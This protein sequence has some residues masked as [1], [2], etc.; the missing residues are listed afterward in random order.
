VARGRI[1]AAKASFRAALDRSDAPGEIAE[2]FA[3]WLVSR[4]DKNDAFEVSER[5][6]A[7]GS[8]PDALLIAS[9][10]ERAA[11]RPD[12]AR[13]MAEKALKLGAPAGRA[14]ILSAQALA[15]QGQRAAA[16][17]TYLG[18]PLDAPEAAEA[19]LRA[20][21]LLRDD[22]KYDDAMR[23]LEAADAAKPAASAGGKGGAPE[24][25]T[26]EL[27]SAIHFDLVISRS[28]IDEKRGDA[29]MAAR[30]L[31]EALA[32]SPDDGRLLIA[33]AGVEE[34][35]GGARSRSPSVSCSA[36]PAASRRSTSSASSPPTTA[37]KR[38]ARS[39]ACRR[40]RR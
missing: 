32:K 38:R 6:T 9:R 13:A 12:R 33:R 18:V 22:G 15:D 40:P 27:R 24:A 28:A 11:K 3:G 1:D 7:E 10:I 16:V 39:S 37:S 31:D 17:T 26:K 30:R 23:A 35:T 34:G 29:A 25:G 21:E 5:F 4:G 20:A 14:A 8:G 2:A 36:S 19:R